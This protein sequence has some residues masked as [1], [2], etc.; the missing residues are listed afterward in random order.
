M[1]QAGYE[2]MDYAGRMIAGLKKD[3]VESL[4]P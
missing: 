1:Q 4:N 3:F 2:E